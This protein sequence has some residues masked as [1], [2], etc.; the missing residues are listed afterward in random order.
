MSITVCTV[1]G[2][3]GTGKSTVSSGIA[4]AAAKE[5]QKVLLIDLDAGLGCLDII[6]GVEESVVFRLDDALE[7]GDITKA[8]YTAKNY[9][10]IFIVP[11]P[12]KAERIDF[13]RLNALVGSIKN[14]YDLIILDFPAGADFGAYSSFAD[15]R[16]LIV[17]GA[18]DVSVKAAAAISRGLSSFAKARLVINRFDKDMMTAGYYRNID[19]VIDTAGTQLLGIVPADGELLLLNRNHK[20]KQKG[21]AFKAFDRIYKRISGEEVPLPKLKKI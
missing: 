20:I 14:D 16:F 2:K 12:D 19:A 6:F 13:K 18:D 9:E 21:R 4:I 1:S 5:G 3:G 15:A 11:A 7:D 10:N 17:T 8:L